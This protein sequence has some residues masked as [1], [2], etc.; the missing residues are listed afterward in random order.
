MSNDII[1][2]TNTTKPISF[3]DMNA[4]IGIT[5]S[6]ELNFNNTNVSRL[7]GKSQNGSQRSLSEAKKATSIMTSSYFSAL[8]YF[9]VGGTH[10]G[11]IVRKNIVRDSEGGWKFGFGDPNA[12]IDQLYKAG[13]AQLYFRVVQDNGSTMKSQSSYANWTKLVFEGDELGDQPYE[14][15]RSS[16]SWSSLNYNWYWNSGTGTYALGSTSGV[17]RYVRIV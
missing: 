6:V 12:K 11:S 9:R 13:S 3:S 15:A 7:I 16:G 4:G 5:G 2:T 10:T 1:K 17:R 8:G 14:L